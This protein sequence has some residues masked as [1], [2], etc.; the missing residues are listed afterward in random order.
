[1]T[2][3]KEIGNFSDQDMIFMVGDYLAS[4][5]EEWYQTIGSSKTSWS[6]FIRNFRAQFISEER[7][8]EEKQ[9]LEID[10]NRVLQQ[11]KSRDNLRKL[12]SEKNER[13]SKML[14]FSDDTRKS[15]FLQFLLKKPDVFTG[16]PDSLETEQRL[17]CMIKLKE[18][19]WLS[20]S[21]MIFIVGDYVSNIA[22]DWYRMV[23]SKEITWLSF[24]QAFKEKFI[25]QDMLKLQKKALQS[26]FDEKNSVT[27]KNESWFN[28]LHCRLIKKPNT[29]SGE[30]NPLVNWYQVVGSKKAT[31][32]EFYEDFKKKFIDEEVLKR[33]KQFLKFRFDQEFVPDKK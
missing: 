3:M 11:N 22:K 23:G 19:G 33:Q 28:L 25:D 15:E 26:K 6:A 31:W 20:D 24:S 5:A 9:G 32:F 13:R 17:E 14:S 29:F 1:M 27:Q 16:E 10:F 8:K 18:F 7:V 30:H 12:A 21:Y 4:N 2:K